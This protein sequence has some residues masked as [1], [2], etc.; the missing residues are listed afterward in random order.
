MTSLTLLKAEN[1]RRMP[2]KNGSGETVEIAIFPQGA[3]LDDFDWRIST[4]TVSTDGAFSVFRDIDRTLSIIEGAGIE[5][6]ISGIA[7]VRL[8]RESP[9]HAF[10]ADVETT[11]RLIAGP[12]TDLNVMTRRGRFD[13]TLSR[14]VIATPQT[15]QADGDMTLLHL[16]G[17]TSVHRNG[18]CLTCRAGDTVMFEKHSV[19]LVPAQAVELFI[20]NLRRANSSR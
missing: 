4:A 13:H 6:C 16:R 7:P 11:A 2:W 12:I 10:P 8:N 17:A 15:I 1:Y 3:S 18:S 14:R 9:P 20:V 19:D 5:L